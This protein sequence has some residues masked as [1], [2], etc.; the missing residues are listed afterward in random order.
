MEGI[1]LFFLY[2]HLIF[3]F[4]PKMIIVINPMDNMD[5]MVKGITLIKEEAEEEVIVQVQKVHQRKFVRINLLFQ[6]L[7]VN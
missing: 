3:V 1:I 2:A 4:F 6:Q 5:N 7:F